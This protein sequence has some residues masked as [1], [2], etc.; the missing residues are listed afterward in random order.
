MEGPHFLQGW[1]GYGKIPHKDQPD[2]QAWLEEWEGELGSMF[3]LLSSMFD[4]GMKPDQPVPFWGL[5]AARWGRETMNPRDYMNNSYDALWVESLCSL[6]TM[7]GDRLGISLKDLENGNITTAAAQQRAAAIRNVAF[8][9]AVPGCGRPDAQGQYQSVQY[10]PAIV[11][12]IDKIGANPKFKVGDQVRCINQLAAG[13]TRQYPYFRGKVG[14]IVAYYGL[15]AERRDAQ[16]QI[17]FQGVYY[18]P[19]PEI[20]SRG[21]QKF[22]TPVYNVRF[23]NDEIWGEDFGDHRMVVYADVYEPYIKLD[24]NY[25]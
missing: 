13:H 22:Y 1:A 2:S 25:A 19:Y 23:E 17:E 8:T 20:A 7:Y 16:G 6:I 15:A 9:Q 10:D 21:L 18:G 11:G 5:D 3:A 4:K 24:D 14:T 12:S